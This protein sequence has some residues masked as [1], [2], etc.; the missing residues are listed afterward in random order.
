MTGAC[1]EVPETCGNEACDEGEDCQV[2][3]QDC[4]ECC[5]D[6]SC[7]E[8][9]GENCTTCDTDCGCAEGTAC[10]DTLRSC[11]E[12]CVPDCAG[13]ACGPDGCGGSCG[14]CADGECTEQQICEG[15]AAPDAP[16]I[17]DFNTNVVRLTEG[18]TVVFTA[19][20]TDPDGAED[21]IG[22]NMIDPGT[23]ATYGA[24]VST[25]GSEGAYSLMLTWAAI[26]TV[27][28]LNFGT[29]EQERRFQANFFDAAG[30]MVN[31]L[32]TL[33]MYCETALGACGDGTCQDLSEDNDN[34]GDCGN[35]CSADAFC[36]DSV[37]NCGDDTVECGG[38]CVELDF[39]PNHCGAC[40][41]VCDSGICTEGFC[42]CTSNDH[43]ESGESC[44]FSSVF[45]RSCIDLG[46]TRVNEA[47]IPLMIDGL[48]VGIAEITSPILEGSIG[49]PWLTFC[50]PNDMQADLL[51]KESMGND[52]E[53][54]LAPEELFGFININQATEFSISDMQCPNN[55]T[56]LNDCT[57]EN[58]DLRCPDI[59]YIVCSPE[60]SF[61]PENELEGGCQDGLDSDFDGT[62]DCDD[63]DCSDDP[64]CNDD[65]HV[66][67]DCLPVE[68]TLTGRVTGN[69]TDGPTDGPRTGSFFHVYRFTPNQNAF[70]DFTLTSNAF[71]TYLYLVE[72]NEDCRVLSEDDD[73]GGGRNSRIRYNMTS[74][75]EYLLLATSFDPNETGAYTL[76][77]E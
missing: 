65:P 25:G 24:F 39:D 64:A 57:F 73:G 55:A 53:G 37:C 15:E 54:R 14:E 62:T 35:T 2:C 3:P 34:C 52:F 46:T 23:G 1:Q 63:S 18:E 74:G 26:D 67:D 11:V 21:V 9:A 76:I 44:P 33:T 17:L 28:T 32:V 29:G 49:S 13:K 51:C 42:E 72:N 30:N 6:G 60:G 75:T 22:G 38:E 5:G 31:Q 69:L 71:D 47:E 12:V 43:C 8:G 50:N 58:L 56:R 70:Y 36:A 16:R 10:E 61:G 48:T 77:V 40:G 20:V 68:A 19:L 27:E 45:S 59:N 66:E 4:G 7:D 41:N